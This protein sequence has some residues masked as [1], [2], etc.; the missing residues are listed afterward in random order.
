[1]KKTQIDLKGN[2]TTSI[3]VSIACIVLFPPENLNQSEY[4]RIS[5]K[6]LYLL[7]L[8]LMKEKTEIDYNIYESYYINDYEKTYHSLKKPF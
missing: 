3:V 8:F 1:M 5:E 4:E 7:S 2:K 6:T